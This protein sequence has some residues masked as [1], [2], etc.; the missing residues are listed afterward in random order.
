MAGVIEIN[1]IDELIDAMMRGLDWYPKS[2]RPTRDNVTVEPYSFDKR[3]NWNTHI[4][5]V[6]GDAW[7]FTDGPL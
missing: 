3:I 7:G 2:K 4:V 6:N 5:C 1:G